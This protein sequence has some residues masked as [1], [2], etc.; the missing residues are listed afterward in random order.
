MQMMKGSEKR[1]ADNP[2]ADLFLDLSIIDI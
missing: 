2:I 1:R